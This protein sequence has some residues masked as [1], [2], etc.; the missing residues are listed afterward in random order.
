MKSAFRMLILNAL[1]LSFAASIAACNTV[2]GAGRDLE[3]AG[4]E[5]Q[6][7]AEDHD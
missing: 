3:K 2:K 5:I 1:V 4:E 7:E 6:E